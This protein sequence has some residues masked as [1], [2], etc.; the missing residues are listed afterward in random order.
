M[1]QITSYFTLKENTDLIICKL[2]NDEIE[3]KQGF[4][5]LEIHMALK[6]IDQSWKNERFITGNLKND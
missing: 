3:L 2:C 5:I 1:N 4:K 6:H